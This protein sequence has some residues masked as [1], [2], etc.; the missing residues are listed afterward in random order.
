MYKILLSIRNLCLALLLMP[1]VVIAATELRDPTQP[2]LPILPT[3]N[4]EVI[5]VEP[6][7]INI[8][9]IFID[10][11]KSRVMIGKNFFTLGDKILGYKIIAITPD[12]ITLQAENGSKSQIAISYPA[13]KFPITNNQSTRENQKKQPT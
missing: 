9:A 2:L 1:L 4:Q 11:Q 6:Q 8:S 7:E 13:V 5:N 12:S 10:Q 3:T